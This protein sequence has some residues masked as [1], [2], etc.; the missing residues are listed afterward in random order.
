MKNLRITNIVKDIA[1][2]TPA[3]DF[4]LRIQFEITG[5]DGSEESKVL[6]A[7]EYREAGS[8]PTRIYSDNLSLT[9]AAEHWAIIP[10]GEIHIP[11]NAEVSI[12]GMIDTDY[13]PYNNY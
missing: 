4:K 3:G 8:P 7:G 12:W 1:S 6:F 2:L 13:K 9:E 10:A 11:N 5:T